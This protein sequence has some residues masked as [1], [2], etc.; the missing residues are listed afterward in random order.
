[1]DGAKEDGWGKGGWGRGGQER[2]EWM[3]Q[4]RMDGAEEDQVTGA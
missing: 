1:M 4:R 2:V 3:G